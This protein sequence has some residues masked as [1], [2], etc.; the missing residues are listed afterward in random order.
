MSVELLSLGALS[1]ADDARWRELAAVAVERN[2]FFEPEFVGP[3][4]RRLVTRATPSLLV[5]HDSHGWAA[6]MP[7]R[8]ALRFRKLP[9]PALLSWVHEHCFLGTPLMAPDRIVPAWRALLAHVGRER[10]T[11]FLGLELLGD[12]GAVARGLSDALEQ[13]GMRALLYERWERAALDRRED[14]DYLNPD[15]A[16]RHRKEMRRQARRLE[17]QLGAPLV[18]C[19]R[20]D[21][22]AALDTFLALEGAGWKGRAGTALAS[23]GRR[24]FFEETARGFAAAGRLQ[25][26]ALEAGDRTLAMKC[27]LLAGDAIYCFKIAYD[28]ALSRFSP[29]IQLELAN[30]DIFHATP[31]A[32][33]TDSCAAPDNQMI[34]RLW[35]GRRS[36]VTVLVP[37]RRPVGSL[38]GVTLRAALQARRQLRRS[39]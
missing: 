7:V 19:D 15:L 37:G 9:G 36:V 10:T 27:N 12:D 34:N 4:V 20:S 2:P 21:E 22:P 39:Q 25:L 1:T 6:C 17:E 13:E 14:G 33:W 16:G 31:G 32:A 3:A 26:L 35:R 23:A 38:A 11:G 18:T 8:R 29:G 5:V 28:E 30:I 24:E